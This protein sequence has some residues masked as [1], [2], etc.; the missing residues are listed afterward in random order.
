MRAGR[1]DKGL[2]IFGLSRDAVA[3]LGG[4]GGLE[5]GSGSV[6]VGFA[7]APSLAGARRD[8]LGRGLCLVTSTGHRTT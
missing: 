1:A 5:H 8:G 7:G 2:A 4:S 6:T 3:R